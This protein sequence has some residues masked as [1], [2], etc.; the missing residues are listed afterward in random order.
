MQG[1]AA[2]TSVLLALS[3]LVHEKHALGGMG[4]VLGA[5][6]ACAETPSSGPLRVFVGQCQI[7]AGGGGPF[8]GINGSPHRQAGGGGGGGD[9]Q[10]GDGGD[11][12]VYSTGSGGYSYTM[13]PLGGEGPGSGPINRVSR[14]K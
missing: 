7:V 10:G 12:S 1:E 8:I 13:Q 2:H 4:C 3:F 14:E 6:L 11:G 5:L 9:D